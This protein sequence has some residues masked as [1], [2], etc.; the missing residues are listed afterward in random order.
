MY[1]FFRYL[2]MK[3]YICSMRKFKLFILQIFES[4]NINTLYMNNLTKNAVRT[5]SPA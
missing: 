3:P 5:S 1:Y 4:Y 2:H